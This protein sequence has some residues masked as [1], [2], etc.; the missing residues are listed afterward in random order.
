MCP[1]GRPLVS[2]F[3]MTVAGYVCLQYV[4]CGGSFYE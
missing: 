1:A 2:H 4:S 3:S